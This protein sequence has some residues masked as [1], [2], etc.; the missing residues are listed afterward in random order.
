MLTLFPHLKS[1][2]AGFERGGVFRSLVLALEQHIAF[3]E[4]HKIPVKQRFPELLI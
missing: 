1:V 2:A 3:A 4:L